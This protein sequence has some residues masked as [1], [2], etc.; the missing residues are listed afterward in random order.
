MH[1]AIRHITRFTYD[2]PIRESVM[3]IR[4]QPRTELAQRCL[5]FE[6][7]TQP[8]AHVSS[9]V[10]LM[11]NIVHHFD[12]PS[13]HTE[14]VV[15]AQAIVEFVG[16]NDLATPATTSS[17][18]GRTSSRRPGRPMGG[19]WSGRRPSFARRRSLQEFAR[20]LEIDRAIDPGGGDGAV[21]RRAPVVRVQDRTRRASTH[22]S[23]KRWPAVRASARTSPTS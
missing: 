14:L 21:R 5:R 3:E 9:Y 6:L 13:E 15:T 22:R 2:A 11:G 7:A 17:T 20:E 1:Y 23:T 18:P 12:I 4:M 19:R 10:D 16:D 8:R